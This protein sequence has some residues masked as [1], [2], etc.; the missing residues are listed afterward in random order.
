VN[1]GNFVASPSLTLGSMNFYPLPGQCQGAA[2]DLASVSSELDYDKDFNGT[3]K[4]G[5][6]FRG[7]YAGEGDNPGWQL[8]DDLK[9]GGGSTPPTGG[10]GGSGTGGSGTGGSGASSSGGNASGGAPGNGGSSATPGGSSDED[11]GCGCRTAPER[12]RVELVLGFGA[13][14]LA[15][16]GRRRAQRQGRGTR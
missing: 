5:F 4:G 12:T 15:L 6:T 1:A 7:A 3:S 8:T 14:A 13:L 9:S 16:F 2:L 10:T 11:G